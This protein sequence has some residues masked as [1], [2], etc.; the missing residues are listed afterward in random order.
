[1]HYPYPSPCAFRRGLCNVCLLRQ[2]FAISSS[3]I[4]LICST[5]SYSDHVG[6]LA[7][8]KVSCHVYLL[9]V[10]WF[11]QL[12]FFLTV[13]RVFTTKLVQL[14]QNSKYVLANYY[15]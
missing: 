15:T 4:Q 3:G 6:A 12:N 11:L 2:K 5:P 7:L 9:C 8:K 1:M 13:D 14:Y 10:I